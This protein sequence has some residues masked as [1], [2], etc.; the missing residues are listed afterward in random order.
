MGRITNKAI[1]TASSLRKSQPRPRSSGGRSRYSIKMS[2]LLSAAMMLMLIPASRN[3][4][5]LR[6][7]AQVYEMSG[8]LKTYVLDWVAGEYLPKDQDLYRVPTGQ[9]INTWRQVIAAM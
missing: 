8:N 4:V 2:L 5:A 3:S 6:Q 1:H 7:T 9:G